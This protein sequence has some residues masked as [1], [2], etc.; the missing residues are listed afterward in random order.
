MIIVASVSCIYG[1]GD[2]EDYTDLMISLRPG[3]IR[4]R[5][6]VIRKLVDIQ[7]E[8]N[9]VDFRRGRFRVRGDVLEI[10]PPGSTDHVLRV[11]FFGDEIERLTEVDYLTGEIIG[12]RTHAA[13][14]PANHYATTRD[15]MLRAVGS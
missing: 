14:F 2:P 4:D 11:E 7:Y 15:K 1:L 9:E 8:R 6:E 13:I 5:D 10:F 3:M 12:A